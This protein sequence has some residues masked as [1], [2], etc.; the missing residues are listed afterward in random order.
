MFYY[1][2]ILDDKRL[3][4]DQIYPVVALNSK[5]FSSLFNKKVQAKSKS[6]EDDITK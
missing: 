5:A 3:K 1:K 6:Q 4:K 2:L